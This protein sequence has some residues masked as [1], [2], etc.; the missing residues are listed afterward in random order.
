M[1]VV[2]AEVATSAIVDAGV[3]NVLMKAAVGA[4]DNCYRLQMRALHLLK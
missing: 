3:K 1:A 2:D 4:E